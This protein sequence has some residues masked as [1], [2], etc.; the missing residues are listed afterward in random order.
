M[1][2][3]VYVLYQR[4][5]FDQFRAFF[6]QIRPALG[7]DLEVH[8][9]INDED[10]PQLRSLE[11]RKKHLHVHCENRNLGVAGGRNYLIAKARATGAEFLVSCDTD[12]LFSRDYFTRL[13]DGYMA[14]QASDPDLGYVQ[15]ILLNGP[16]VL[17]C[18]EQMQV[19]SWTEL[20]ERL[21]KKSTDWPKDLWQPVKDKLGEEKAVTAIFHTGVTNLWRAHFDAPL[22]PKGYVPGTS[23]A[24][25]DRFGTTYPTLRSEPGQLAEIIAKGAPVRIMSSAGG[26][27]AFHV[28][29][30]DRSGTYNDLFNPFAFED[31]ELGWRSTMSGLNN[32]LLPDV[33]AIHDIFLGD[34]NRSA[35]YQA[36]IGVLRGAEI[37]GSHLSEQ[38]TNYALTQS[39]FKAPLH[40]MERFLSISTKDGATPEQNAQQLPSLFLSYYWEFLRGMLDVVFKRT[41]ADLPNPTPL[42]RLLAGFAGD[43][44][45]GIKDFVL[46]LEG[47]ELRAAKV[48]AKV[49]KTAGNKSV[50]GFSAVNCRIEEP[51]GDALL[52][53]RFF[54]LFVRVE[55][56]ENQRYRITLD[57]QS[58]EFLH[59]VQL[60]LIYQP[61]TA[62]KDGILALESC[63]LF[64]KEH[65]YGKFS[66]EDIYP[67]PSLASSTR[68]L[69]M[70]V[71]QFARARKITS[72]LGNVQIFLAALE[73]YLTL[74][75]SDAQAAIAKPA[76]QVA[77][78]APKDTLK[79]G[80]KKVLIF[81][82][83]RGQHKPAGTNHDI[84][85]ERLAKD[86][87][88]DVE[89]YLCPMKWTTTL[90]FLE[91]FPE[92]KLKTYD[93]VILYTGIVEWSPRP[94]PS[95][96]ADLYDNPSSTNA[97]NLGLNTRD[98]SKK[99]VN[100][101]KAAFNTVFGAGPAKQYLETPFDTEYEGEKTINMYGL[102]MARTHLLPRLKKI[103]NLIFITANRFSNGWEGDFKR[104]RPE[105]IRITHEYSDLF[106]EELAAAGVPLV[107]LRHWDDD[108]IKTFT[109]D[110]IHLSERGSNYIYDRLSQ[111]LFASAQAGDHNAPGD[112]KADDDKAILLIGNG[113]SSKALLQYGFEN[114]PKN[115]DT[116]GCGA[117][118]RLFEQIDW[119]P[120]YYAWCDVKVVKS[121]QEAFKKIVEDPSIPTEYFYFSLKV[122]PSKR[123]IEVPHGSTGDFLL[124]KANNFGYKKIYLIGMEGAYTE[125]VVGSRSITAEEYNELGL[126]SLRSKMK[127]TL[128]TEKGPTGLFFETIRVIDKTP[129]KN[130][131]Y[132]FEGYQRTGDLYSLPRAQTHQNAWRRT[133][134]HV[135]K[136]GSE[137]INLSS[138]S[139]ITEFPRADFRETLFPTGRDAVPALT[140]PIMD[141]Q[142]ISEMRA[143]Q[144]RVLANVAPDAA[145]AT[146]IIALKIKASEPERLRN[147]V[148]VVDWI[149]RCYGSLVDILIVEQDEVSRWSE[150]SDLLPA[151]V[152]HEFL[153]NPM[154]F[155][156]GWGYNCAI[157]HFCTTDVACLMDSD[158][159][160]GS[161]LFDDILQCYNGKNL[162]SPYTYVHFTTPE[163]TDKV[164]VS[165]S[166][167]VI[168]APNIQKPTTLTGG[169]VIVRRDVFTALKGFEQYIEYAGE[170]RAL[171][172]TALN[173]LPPETIAQSP[174]TY[175]HLHHPVG[176]EP[177]PHAMDLFRHLRNEFG[178]RVAKGIRPK[179]YVHGQCNHVDKSKTLSM[180]LERARSFGDLELYS[181]GEELPI[182]GVRSPAIAHRMDEAVFPPN[183][184]N[185]TDYSK[186]ELYAN[187]PAPDSHELAQFYN[188]FKGQRCFIVGN[189][190]SLNN[191][192]LSLL[193][194]EYSFAVNSIYYKTRESGFRPTF[195]VVEDSAV[196]K[197]N[198]E[199]I[200]SY[201]APFKFF[202]TIYRDLHPK[203]PNTFFFDMNR[204][205]YEKTSPNYAVPRFSTDA[206]D[207]LYCGQSVTYIN[208]QLAFFM[209]FTEVY[210][211]G[212][213][214]DYVIP[215]S[216][217][218]T[219]DNI[220]STTD[221]PN[222][223][224]K[225]YFGKGK[226]WKD[227]K[228]ERVLMNYRQ[229]DIAYT[230]VERKIYNATVGG[231]LEVFDRVDYDKLLLDPETGKKRQVPA[232][233]VV[234]ARAS[235]DRQ[236]GREAP[237]SFQILG[238]DVSGADTSSTDLT[239]LSAS[240]LLDP[241]TMLPRVEIGGDLAPKVEA[242][243]NAGGPLAEHLIKVRDWARKRVSSNSNIETQEKAG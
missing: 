74:K 185:L 137:V 151:R 161:N 95:A 9:L 225:D 148:T 243:I 111:H 158:V 66:V 26:V 138:I 222:H 144:A 218:R 94:A 114:L 190:P 96:L 118:Y 103:P 175:V 219:G 32:Y 205:F 16:S 184:K 106:A 13:R 83:S 79:P 242:V 198:L 134:T 76:A 131:N 7:K 146:A 157:R 27:T 153:Y 37:A 133:S 11:K 92:E 51:S 29:A 173:H 206:T 233:P 194:G 20:A 71:Q 191:H 229:A 217:K 48:E 132:F 102:D 149:D 56:D 234:T 55:E 31:S 63:D 183:F 62:A 126:D 120:R 166:V 59:K 135:S 22:N 46:P 200:R 202:P 33:F 228:L 119:W 99:I 28:R 193:E 6:A 89:V 41:A 220:L 235:L 34:N 93:H 207:V 87:R 109:C 122:S 125:E 147:L 169:I 168:G 21:E 61:D 80:K 143:K 221:D 73:H 60:N 40:M 57:V 75:P 171:D 45:V 236:M 14:L 241:F 162:V 112:A 38:D 90:D 239:T 23:Q 107:D 44:P 58:D 163:E 77:K 115:I 5:E 155:N 54:D 197:E 3:A 53:S 181:C 208:L 178:C 180:L 182:N 174:Y 142:P 176:G 84:F 209:G 18:F 35:M 98:Y 226:T 136:R 42:V 121:H 160:P 128:A 154:S 195:F 70:I 15:P 186:R 1:K 91:R 10:C 2:T 238:Q 47:A 19:Q 210:L 237:T 170:D 188:R 116:F 36:R 25:A 64:S 69:P 211:I 50:Y 30:M 68:W 117:A 215:K 12:I 97:E 216:H 204:G 67:A 141:A 110:N 17:D 231:K 8:V 187:T 24:L 212:M 156:R 101:K 203:E 108:Q 179:D 165:N 113:P 189:G 159:L 201:E 130:P 139:Q 88:L 81:T 214:F 230:A 164:R 124:R 140:F 123:Q 224:H 43:T 104:G 232:R 86:D 145:I 199:E 223:Y 192:D 196:M 82:D 150:I 167:E 49:G 72:G 52:S 240:L 39:L 172:V 152:R 177:R 4:H 65:D 227:P 213:D 105:N 100:N 127:D 129:E 78:P 85:A